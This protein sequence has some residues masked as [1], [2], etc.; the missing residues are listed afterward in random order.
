MAG[1]RATKRQCKSRN[2]K[3]R[4]S[5]RVIGLGGSGAAILAFGVGPLGMAPAAHA[6]EFGAIIDPIINS[7]AGWM[8]GA[9]PSA[10][11]AGLDLSG[12]G[13]DPSSPAESAATVAAGA[14]ASAVPSSDPLTEL[15]SSAVTS[16][17]VVGNNELIITDNPSTGLTYIKDIDTTTGAQVGTTLALSGAPSGIP[18]VIGNDVLIT[19]DNPA[20]AGG[21][22]TYVYDIDIATG[23]KGGTT[24]AMSGTPLFECLSKGCAP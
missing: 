2:A 4:R 19:T 18:E 10:G 13:L 15:S 24:I 6:D 11:L 21:G 3:T 9:D 22:V 8:E 23:A 16:T 14:A 1:Q 7:I 5:R 12:M 20:A 17:E